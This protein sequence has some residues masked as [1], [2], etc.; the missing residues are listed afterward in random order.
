MFIMSIP[1]EE[2]TEN[3]NAAVVADGRAVQVFPGFDPRLT[4]RSPWVDRAC[5]QRYDDLL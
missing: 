5:F 2:G 4:I 3:F 1:P